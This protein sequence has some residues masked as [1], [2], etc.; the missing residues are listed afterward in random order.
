MADVAVGRD[1]CGEQ[2]IVSLP[3][4][5][6]RVIMKSSPEVS[7]INQEALMLTAKATVRR[8]SAGRS[9]ER[10]R[11]W[12]PPGLAALRSPF[13]P[14][15][16]RLPFTGSRLRLLRNSPHFPSTPRAPQLHPFLGPTLPAPLPSSL[17]R[18]LPR[19]LRAAPAFLR[20]R[21]PVLPRAA[22][23]WATAQTGARGCCTACR[24]AHLWTPGPR[25]KPA[26]FP[27]VRPGAW[28]R[29]PTPQAV[30]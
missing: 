26:P 25:D 9:E 5:R 15:R 3:L 28:F 23:S 19:P 16:R 7:S 2:R 22:V 17:A 4:S 12:G 8:G 20:A 18:P 11:G 29:A 6:I 13:G 27:R 10:G 30:Q 21:R 1:K 14:A 24:V